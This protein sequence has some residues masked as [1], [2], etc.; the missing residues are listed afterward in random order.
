MLSG[1]E[2]DTEVCGKE[3][4]VLQD[5]VPAHRANK[6]AGRDR[7]ASYYQYKYEKF[8]MLSFNFSTLL[9]SP[10]LYV[11]STIAKEVW[12]DP[13]PCKNF[14]DEG[15][16]GQFCSDE[17]EFNSEPYSN[18]RGGTDCWCPPYEG[19]DIEKYGNNY[20]WSHSGELWGHVTIASY[21]FP[22]G[23]KYFDWVQARGPFAQDWFNCD[24][25]AP[26]V[27]NVNLEWAVRHCDSVPMSWE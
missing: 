1:V 14:Y 15:E 2:V 18:S 27:E 6:H 10:L 12:K 3:E 17:Y 4:S 23:V 5:S 16:G 22:F 9:A 8:D 24:P 11:T 20:Y 26:D 19:K 7:R 25:T 13:A 21:T